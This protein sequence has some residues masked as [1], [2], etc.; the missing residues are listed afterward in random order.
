MTIDASK[1]DN[2]QAHE[3]NKS[4]CLFGMQSNDFYSFLI[5]D[6]EEAENEKLAQEMEEEVKSMGRTRRERRIIRDRRLASKPYSP[7][8]YAAKDS[9]KYT[10][11]LSHSKKSRSK[12]L[13]PEDQGSVTYITSFGCDDEQSESGP[14]PAPCSSSRRRSFSPKRGRKRLCKSRSRSRSRSSSRSHRR[15]RS[16]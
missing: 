14:L 10:S 15:N 7:P 13:S 12:S 1:L 6:I 16:R 3:L 9:P 8:S 4:G 5:N 2:T 11:E